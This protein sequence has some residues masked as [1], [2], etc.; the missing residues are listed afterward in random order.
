MAQATGARHG[1]VVGHILGARVVVRWSSLLTM[2]LLALV[3]GQDSAGGY[4]NRS[5]ATG[6]EY[7]A[8]VFGSLFLHEFAH[9][10]AGRAFGREIKEIA[11]TL[12]GA[13]TSFDGR[14]LSATASGVIAAAG[15]AM[16]AALALG[17]FAVVRAG[18]TGGVGEA[19]RLTAYANILL[20]VFNALP[21]IP[22]DGGKVLEA[23]VWGISGRQRLGIVAAAWGGRV[24][25]IGIVA[26][27][28]V[29]NFGAGH[30]PSMFSLMWALLIVSFLW[31]AS[32]AAL[33]GAG[34]QERV[35]A[36]TVLALMRPAIG[37]RYEATVGAA[38]REATQANAEQVVVLS[39]DGHPAGHFSVAGALEVPAGRR[40]ATGL[41]AVT[42]PLPRGA[43]V[44]SD[45]T[46]RAVLEHGREW[47]G[48]T[49]AVAVMDDGEVVGLVV[50]AEVGERLK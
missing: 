34:V 4:S 25:V 17:A 16:N 47:W 10:I 3:W 37:I 38:V 24:V 5:L 20:A 32:T 7:A 1:W 2:V 40:D 33:R 30:Q 35:D 29:S 42:V 14:N 19:L 49:D 48:K 27:V 23:V 18:V 6:V 11:L 9:A 12:M 46:G 39:T 13:H 8:I 31:P 41:A 15:P 21:G 26:Y 28:G 44:R 45:L 43:E 50:L 22:M 36:V